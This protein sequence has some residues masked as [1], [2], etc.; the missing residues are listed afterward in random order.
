[1]DQPV[2]VTTTECQTLH[3]ELMWTDAR[4]DRHPLKVGPPVTIRTEILGTTDIQSHYDVQC[5]GGVL[6]HQGHQIYN[7]NRWEQRTITLDKQERNSS[8][9]WSFFTAN[10]RS[11]VELY[12]YVTNSLEN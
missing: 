11:K 2:D 3:D 9:C 4:G 7:L 8:I 6:I 1:M 10:Y 12:R 5:V